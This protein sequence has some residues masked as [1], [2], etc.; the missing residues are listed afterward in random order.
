MKNLISALM[1][2]LLIAAASCKQKA[3]ENDL[4]IPGF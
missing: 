1:V 4:L 2:F 3:P